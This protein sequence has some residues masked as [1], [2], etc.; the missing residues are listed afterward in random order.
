MSSARTAQP[1]SRAPATSRALSH[2]L[3]LPKTSSSRMM[4]P[5]TNESCHHPRACLEW[6]DCCCFGYVADDVA[7]PTAD[8]ESLFAISRIS[9][10]GGCRYRKLD[11]SVAMM[12]TADHG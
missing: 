5:Q 8:R 11:S 7:G 12:Q 10:G 2:P 6:W 4:A 1:V 9:C 3:W